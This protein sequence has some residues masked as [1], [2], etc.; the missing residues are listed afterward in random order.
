MAQLMQPF[1]A[2]QHDPTQSAGQ[3]P[4]G[5]HP[6]VI[7]SSEI[8]A[9]N[10]GDGGMLV[11]NLQ[12]IDG[13]QKGG[14]GVYRLNLYHQTNEQTVQI[15]HKQLSAICYV[16]GVF[17]VANTEQMHNIP[18]VVEV[19]PQKNDP[20]YTEVKKVYD[21]QGNE[22]GKTGQAA[23]AAPAATTPAAVAPVQPNVA[24]ATPPVATP[25][26][27]AP[28]AW[29]APAETAPPP[30]AAAP[31]AWTPAPAAGGAAPAN[32]PAAGGKAPWEA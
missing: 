23:P 12:I 32:T 19:G 21:M 25:T 5:K 2:S 17:N 10:A 13:P 9:T 31:A 24:P 7:T 16:I 11:F 6:V 30:N 20:Q 1:D 18:F 27:P 29:A 28:T 8:K 4:I 26:A 22:P 3:M 14:T 15:A